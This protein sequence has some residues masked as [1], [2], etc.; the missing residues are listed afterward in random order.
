MEIWDFSGSPW[1]LGHDNM[2]F[3]IKIQAYIPIP[4]LSQPSGP[5]TLD[6]KLCADPMRDT[7]LV[8]IR[9]WWSSL[10]SVQCLLS[11]LPKPYPKSVLMISH[12]GPLSMRL[13]CPSLQFFNITPPPP[14]HTHLNYLTYSTKMLLRMMSWLQALPMRAITPWTNPTP[15]LTDL[16]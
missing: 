15:A 6:F 16:L 10:I 2:K 12:S 1:S 9:S 13:L 11:T 4:K 14:T 5:C 8:L 3:S 7:S